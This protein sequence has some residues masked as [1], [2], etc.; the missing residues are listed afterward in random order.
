MFA[1]LPS[2]TCVVGLTV[3]TACRANREECPPSMT[4]FKANRPL[5]PATRLGSSFRGRGRAGD[6]RRKFFSEARL[7]ITYPEGNPFGESAGDHRGTF[8][9]PRGKCVPAP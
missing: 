6:P 3:A 2:V 7:T 9:V 8:R 5:L 1:R 4:S